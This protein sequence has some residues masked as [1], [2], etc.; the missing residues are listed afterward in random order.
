[1]DDEGLDSTERFLSNTVTQESLSRSPVNPN[2]HNPN[3]HLDNLQK[4]SLA[5]L[6]GDL[7]CLAAGLYFAVDLF[8]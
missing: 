7:Q 1:M 5:D 4:L 3:L 6:T 8:Y 2:L